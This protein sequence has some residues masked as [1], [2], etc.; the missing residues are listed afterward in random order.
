MDVKRLINRIRWQYSRPYKKYKLRGLFNYILSTIDTRLQ[1]PF[2]F[3]KPITV[4]ISVIEGICN[5]SCKTCE[6]FRPECK[7]EISFEQ[8]KKLLD[9]LKF[10][11]MV[12]LGGWGEPFMAKDI[13]RIIDYTKANNCRLYVITNMTLINQVA[14][15]RIVE[16]QLDCLGISFDAATK[17]VFERIRP[18]ADFDAI[19]NNI[20]TLNLIK[21]SLHSKKP[22]LCF[23][24]TAMKE[25]I[26][27]IP[28]IVELA[29]QLGIPEIVVNP[30]RV[31]NTGL[32]TEEQS[33]TNYMELTDQ[34]FSL[35]AT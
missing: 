21:K 1:L 23:Q 22:N 31:R 34:F 28:Q 20:K 27:Q 3:A 29:H 8:F 14:A 9:N 30:L 4:R 2:A 32:A 6:P 12:N 24:V 16:S 13:F 33:L 25:N 10:A 17:Q 15:K 19:I 35:A 7:R 11:F 5:L 26:H 18:G